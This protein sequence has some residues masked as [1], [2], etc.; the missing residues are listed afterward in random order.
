VHGS[1]DL[2]KLL[3]VKNDFLIMDFEGEAGKSLAERRKLHPPLKDVASMLRSFSYAA[4]TALNQFTETRRQAYN[5]LEAWSICWQRW[6][7][8]A[9]MRE[10]RIIIGRTPLIPRRIR[11]FEKL[12]RLYLADKTIS[13]LEYELAQRPEWVKIPLNS[14]LELCGFSVKV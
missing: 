3:W 14:L 6:V 10:Y 8:A 7:S 13:E 9:F 2:G 4:Y 5:Q 11:D 1:Y 12:T